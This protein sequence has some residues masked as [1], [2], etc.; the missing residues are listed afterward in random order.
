MS[1]AAIAVLFIKNVFEI[2][3]KIKISK[4]SPV[5]DLLIFLNFPAIYT[6]IKLCWFRNPGARRE[7]LCHLGNR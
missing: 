5:I 2:V 4:S 6:S 3:I 7:F 1:S